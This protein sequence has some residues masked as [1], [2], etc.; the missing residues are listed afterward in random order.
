MRLKNNFFK[1]SL[2]NR[3]GEFI[4][5]L[6]NRDYQ[7]IMR[8][9]ENRRLS[10]YHTHEER[11]KEIYEK[12]PEIQKID[13]EI[14]KNSI[15]FGRKLIFQDDQ[16]I[17]DQYK[18]KNHRLLLEKKRLLHKAGYA[19]DYLEPIYHCKKCKDTGYIGQ[20][21]CTCFQ[22]TII[23]LLYTSSNMDRILAR[24]NFQTFREEYYSDQITPN[25]HPSPRTNIKKIRKHCIDFIS[26]FPAGENILFQ[27][28][29][30]VGKTFLSHCIAKEIM[31]KGYTCV[32]VTAFQLFDH[33]AKHTFQRNKTPDDDNIYSLD[34]ILKADLLII[35][36]LGTEMTNKF[37][38]SQLFQCLNERLIQE[39]STI[40]STNLSV[41]DFRD[42]YSERIFS[43]IIECYSWQKL[44]G[45]DIRFKKSNLT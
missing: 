24:E 16:K 1:N 20:E 8:L 33:L 42:A 12:L 23:N 17:R 25:G 27:G 26:H 18:Q 6:S 40:I 9:Y 41:K 29:T 19:D 38:I 35:D 3:S 43:R 30:G 22:Q 5:P 7:K 44:Y 39:K 13:Q 31:D 10:N 11:K 37:V 15:S 34:M 14:A 32:Y 45:D 2:Q 28:S 36:D 21:K 4:M